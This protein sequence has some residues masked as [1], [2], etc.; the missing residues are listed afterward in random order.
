ML[1]QLPK[2]LTVNNK[3]YLIRTDFRDIFRVISAFNDPDLLDRE[4]VYLC[5]KNIYVNFQDIPTEDYEEAYK[6]AI[7]FIEGDFPKDDRPHPKVVNWE[8]DE[9]LIFPEIN[10]IAGREVREM[11]HLHWWTFLGYFQSIDRDGLW[12][13]VMS[14]RH[15]KATGKNLENYERDFY[16]ANQTMCSV[17]NESSVQTP[18]DCLAEM[19]REL[20]KEGAING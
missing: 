4:K 1:G 15:K 5:M 2:S 12:G 17:E 3:K 20:L 13:M 11:A 6:V 16:S 7:H 14:I 10:K 9:P 18:E 19:Y 8:K